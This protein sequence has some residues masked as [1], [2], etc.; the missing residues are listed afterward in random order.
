MA[1]V[2][3]LALIM[4]GGTGGRLEVLTRT[5]AKPVLPYG[6]VYRLID[7]PLSNCMH[8]GIADVWVIEQYQPH[9]L[10]EHLANG[11]PWDLD[12]TYGGLRLLQ[13]HQGG[14]EGGWH[15]GN[16]DAIYRNRVSIR[17]FDP[18][19]VLVLSADHAYTLDYRVVIDRH[20]EADAAL[21]MVTT[22]VRREE[23]SRFGCVRADEQGC[24]AEFQ[25]KPESPRSDL[26][27][28][29]VFAYKT[30]ELLDTLN[31]LAAAKG[32]GDGEQEGESLED[33]GDELVP[34][35]VGEGRVRE[36]R[37][38]GYWRDVGT[39]HSYWAAQMD[40]LADE[41]GLRLDDPTWPILTR[42]V[43]L[44]PARI[45]ASARI[46]DSLISA[47]S[48]VRGRV[49]RSVLGP[50]VVVEEGATVRHS[51]LLSG[52][53]VEAGATVD[54]AILDDRVRIG[55]GARVGEGRGSGDGPETDRSDEDI[56]VVG[57]RARIAEGIRVP[58][59]ARV[60]PDGTG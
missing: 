4:A 45:H 59:G 39:V 37:L 29:E 55:R 48:T 12:R 14:D 35:L 28:T 25:Y 1:R 54:G 6:G 51:V 17:A 32:D 57:R 23:V 15:Q 7:F 47:G 8:S 24:V 19:V 41:P 16:A 50:G 36:Y 42:G 52:C 56:A 43:Q 49:V 11:R 30:D 21:T 27:T 40:L 31:E 60:E 33:F 34:T 18:E 46:D 26:V 20:L 13:P 3:T 5:R 2:K 9:S 44:S 22:R 58:A 10:N 53:A 38:E